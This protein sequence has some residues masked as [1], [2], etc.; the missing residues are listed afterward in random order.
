MGVGGAGVV[1]VAAA[2][3]GEVVVRVFE[4][5]GG[6]VGDVCLQ[7]HHRSGGFVGGLCHGDAH[8][9][10]VTAGVDVPWWTR[11]VPAMV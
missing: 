9:V 2:N 4:K 10:R 7:V 5:H 8:T 11:L 6:V 1:V 3:V